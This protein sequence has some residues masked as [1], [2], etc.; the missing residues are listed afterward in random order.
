MKINKIYCALAVVSALV[1]AACGG[2]GA[3]VPLGAFADLTATEGDAPIV[4]KAPESKSPAVFA[5][6][7]SNPNVATISGNKVTILLAGT[8]TITAAQPSF[9]SYNPTSTSALL[10]VHARVCTAPATN[11]GGVCVTPPVCTAP[12]T[13]QNG[14]CVAP[15]IAA[16]FVTQN[17]R[18]WMPVTLADTWENANAFCTNTTINGV[19]GWRLPTEFDLTELYASGAISGHGWVLGQTWSS[20]KSITDQL[21]GLVHQAV[22]LATGTAAPQPNGSGAYVTCVR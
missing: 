7:S 1:L 4:L 22:S 10:T 5:Y 8:T 16:N 11:Q 3:G 9:G 14:V 19:T 15:T 17:G 18:S 13:A 12:A 20:S 6:S 21:G 2:G